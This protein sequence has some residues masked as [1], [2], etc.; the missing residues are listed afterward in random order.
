[1][2]YQ[3][4]RNT[5]FK[6][7]ETR[8][9]IWNVILCVV[10]IPSYL[11]CAGLAVGI[12]DRPEFDLTWVIIHFMAAAVGANVCYTLAYAVEFYFAFGKHHE[13]YLERGRSF[14]FF[15]GCVAGIFLAIAGGREIAL[16]QYPV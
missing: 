1:M 5:A 10:S 15:L 13:D 16:L 9:I 11:F 3:S 2:D 8:R 7:W 12:G 4:Y 6:Y 14:V